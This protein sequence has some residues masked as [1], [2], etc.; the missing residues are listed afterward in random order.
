MTLR[1]FILVLFLVFFA[2]IGVASGLYF[3]DAREEHNRLKAIEAGDRR[4]LAEV[5]AQLAEQERILDRLR[6]DPGYVEKVI[7]RKLG[8]AKPDEVIYRF[9][10]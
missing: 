6:T 9:E 4:R 8:Y 3:Y 7:R 5:E 10:E 1:R 2:G